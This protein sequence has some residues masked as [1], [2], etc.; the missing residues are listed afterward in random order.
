MP[1]KKIIKFKDNVL[2]KLCKER[3]KEN[4]FVK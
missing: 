3:Q 4:K 2:F 1:K